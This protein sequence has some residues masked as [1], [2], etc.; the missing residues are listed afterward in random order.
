MDRQDWFLMTRSRGGSSAVHYCDEREARRIAQHA[1]LLGD[2]VVE[3]PRP[4]TVEEQRQ[5]GQ[6][7]P[8]ASEVRARIQGLDKLGQQSA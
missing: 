2:V 4:L 6:R 1:A 3:G 8:E 7:P 5:R